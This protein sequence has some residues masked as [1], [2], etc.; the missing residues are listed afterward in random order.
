MAKNHVI[1]GLELG[2]TALR[3]AVGEMKDNALNF[4]GVSEI[5]S[6]DTVKNGIVINLD[7]AAEAIS[8]LLDEVDLKIGRKINSA[9]VNISGPDVKQEIANSVI[10]LPQRGCEITRKHLDDLISACK[11]ASVPLDRRLLYIR[12]L[13]YIIDGQG[14]VKEP[15]GLCASRLEA[16]ILIITAP[17]NQTQ[18]IVKALNSAGLDVEEIAPTIVAGARTSLTPEQRNGGAALVDFKT[19]STEL[20]IF[21]GGSP[22]FFET[23]SRGQAPVTEKISARFN[24][25]C[26]I[27]EVLKLKYGFIDAGGGDPR[28]RETIPVEWMGAT[29]NIS[30]GELNKIINEEAGLLLDA[31]AGRIKGIK[32]AGNLLTKGIILT[33]GV[34]STEGFLEMAGQKFGF[35]VSAG[36]SPEVNSPAGNSASVAGGLVKMGFEKRVEAGRAGKL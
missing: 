3:I 15:I 25:P 19:Y 26:Q 10:T 12:P 5:R 17:F 24:I 30:R 11:I 31:V 13:G 22:V 34:V 4:L 35:A 33:G 8:R 21:E 27:A 23:V 7:N 2:N 1:A 28:N 29:R 32:N 9:L 14:G 6:R 18:N 36:A 20:A 16:E